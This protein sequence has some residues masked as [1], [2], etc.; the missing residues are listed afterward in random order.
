MTPPCGPGS[1]LLGE[2]SLPGPAVRAVQ[3][4]WVEVP[5]EPAQAGSFIQQLVDRK[6]N[7]F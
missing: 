6:V 1:V 4:L 2:A 5:L 7:H 3:S